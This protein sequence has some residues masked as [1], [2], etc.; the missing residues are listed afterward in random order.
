M[1]DMKMNPYG[2]LMDRIYVLE[3]S[4]VVKGATSDTDQ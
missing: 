3:K 1:K 2:I 4:E